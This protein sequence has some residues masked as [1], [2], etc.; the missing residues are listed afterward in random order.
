[1]RTFFLSFLFS[2]CFSLAFF[3]IIPYNSSMIKQTKKFYNDAF[4]EIFSNVRFVKS[5]LQDFVREPWVKLINFS[6]MEVTKSQFTGISEDKREA[7][8]LLKFSIKDNTDI[9]IFIMLEFQKTS[10]KMFCRLHDYLNR[11]YRNQA[12]FSG[13]LSVVVPI[14][15]YN[16][17]ETWKEKIRFIDY[18]IIID[19]SLTRFIPNFEYI[20]IDINKFDDRLL[21]KLK[22]EVAYF[23][24]LEKTNLKEKDKS[25]DRILEIF[26]ELKSQDKNLYIMLARY[27][28]NL[29]HY[30]QIENNE[31][32]EYFTEGSKSMLTESL[33]KIKQESFEQGIE[34][35]ELIDKQNI[36]IKLLIKKYGLDK[37]EKKYI[38]SIT[39]F[40]KLD[41]A[42]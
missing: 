35:G 32:F 27:I 7:D 26:Q 36:L 40:K 23:F 42:L 12:K 5:L 37:E 38:K 30:K 8:L 10:E 39:D 41:A 34:K 29:L 16:G 4:I 28:T 19:K 24:L 14:V 1:V 17:S 25:I 22:S 11:I 31:I 13:K 33:E 21:K 18:F 3:L 6:N 9:F 20:L 15:I 2:T